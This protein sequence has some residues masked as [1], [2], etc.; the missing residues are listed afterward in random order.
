MENQAN[1]EEL[2]KL[3]E[4]GDVT[5][6]NQLGN[7]YFQ[8]IGVR[9]NYDESLKW[10]LKSAEQGDKDGQYYTAL[11][12]VTKQNYQ[13]A[14]K[15]SQLAAEQG[16]AEAI[17]QLGWHYEHGFGVEKDE[18]K[19]AALYLQ[20]AEQGNAIAQFYLSGCYGWGKGVEKDYKKALEWAE[21][22]VANGC[23]QAIPAVNH[24]KTFL[25][26]QKEVETNGL[27]T[28]NNT[29]TG[30][31]DKQQ[32]LRMQAEQGDANAQYELGSYYK[33]K[34]S[35]NKT[36][37]E[38]FTKAAEQGHAK[39]QKEVAYYYYEGKIVDQSY[40]KYIEWMTKSANQGN[41]DAQH[42]LG[43]FFDEGADG[44]PQN[45][46]LGAM[47]L[48]KAAEQGDTES[49][50]YLAEHY[51]WGNGVPEDNEKAI[52]WF[53][54]AAE[55]D[56]HHRT[57]KDAQWRMGEIYE[58][59][60]GVDADL[61]VAADWY[62]RAAK[63]HHSQARAD[64]DRLYESGAVE[65]K[66]VAVR[67]D[68]DFGRL[69]HDGKKTWKGKITANF[70]GK[71][72][73]LKLKLSSTAEEK[74]TEAQR[75]A[76]A[77]YRKKETDFYNAVQ[78]R[79]KEIYK[80][81]NGEK[82]NEIIPTVLCID[83]EGNYGWE[84]KKAWDGQNISAILSDGDVQ[85]ASVS[86]VYNY[87]D[88]VASRTKT[89]WY[90]GDTAYMNLFGFLEALDVRRALYEYEEAEDEEVRDGKL[91]DKEVQ[92]LLWLTNELNT[93]SIADGVV[94]Y[95]NITYDMWSD[96]QIGR[97]DLLDELDISKIYLRTEHSAEYDDDPEI[98]LA[99]EC[100]CDEEHG[101]AIG[102]KNK[103]LAGVS[104]EDYGFS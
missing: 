34:K 95:C 90:E 67:K 97:E 10:Y 2:T 68:E 83:R 96:K 58:N 59:G 101:I 17:N 88:V 12:Y 4:Q 56:V 79:A 85:I 51:Y 25:P 43:R 1:I 22:A 87:A 5:A 94:E 89:Q 86:V 74:F 30:I 53:K 52:E 16:Q 37:F 80:K 21:K 47:W 44:V 63:N 23:K 24:Y 84:C 55:G 81:A 78:K 66:D 28:G 72:T 73:E 104:S 29:S 98:S 77:E 11:I 9:K 39:A 32:A 54:K 45:Y 19:A 20:N 65:P 46:E 102:F 93:E 33:W 15:W 75:K 8:G 62:N 38:W 18:K 3:A 61:E 99:G 70:N 64:L 41:A 7:C 91:T 76:F 49:A 27:K 40:E 13:E 82:D 26:T 100:Q 69:I 6:R 48:T 14:V 92:L 50:Y 42:R 36:A 35:D 60:Y 31:K 71:Q 103:E 57:T